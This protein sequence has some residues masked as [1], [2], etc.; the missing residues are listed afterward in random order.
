[1]DQATRR[2]FLRTGLAATVIAGGG[3]AG[4]MTA[5]AAKRSAAD[6]VALGNSGVKVTR[7]A[8][9]TGT[10]SGRVQRALGQDG[11][12]RLIRHAYDRG[13]RFFDTG[14]SY[15]THKMLSIALKGLPRESYRL[16]TKYDDFGKEDPRAK[17]DRFRRELGTEYIDILLIHYLRDPRW[18]ETTRPVQDALSEAKVRKTVLAHGVSEHGLPVLATLPGYKWLDVALVRTNHAGVHMDTPSVTDPDDNGDVKQVVAQLERIHAQGTGVLGMK[19]IA[20][21]LFTKPEEREASI[22]F[23]MG[24]GTVDA[25]TIGYKSIAELDEAIDRVDRALNA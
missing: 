4:A 21:G 10:F 12:T 15:G 14:E 3:G 11:F 23:V 24:L 5:Q 2:D 16:M 1:M 22:R 9:G 8:V 17:L 18:T 6:W 25:I 7:L 13:I 20:E 19:L